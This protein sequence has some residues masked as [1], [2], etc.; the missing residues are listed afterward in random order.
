MAEVAPTET[1]FVTAA[2]TEPLN[3]TFTHRD[4]ELT[5]G[6]LPWGGSLWVHVLYYTHWTHW[7][8]FTGAPV[9]SNHR[10]GCW[11]GTLKMHD[12]DDDH[13]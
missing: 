3:V 10:S 9:E 1:L 13:A 12:E 11:T 7:T 5:H 2:T 8:G 6:R 4:A